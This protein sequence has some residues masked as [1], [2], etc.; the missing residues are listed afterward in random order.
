MVEGIRTEFLE[1][2]KNLNW[3]DAK[4]KEK[5]VEKAKAINNY[6]GYPEQLKNITKIEELYEGVS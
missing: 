2:L 5:A 1:T 3:M 6:I 4:T